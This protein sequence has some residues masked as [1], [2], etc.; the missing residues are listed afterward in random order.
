MPRKPRPPPDDPAQSARFVETAKA[1]E[2][3]GRAFNRALDVIVPPQRKPRKRS[4]KR[5]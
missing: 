1:V 4:R 3:D 5:P 2:T